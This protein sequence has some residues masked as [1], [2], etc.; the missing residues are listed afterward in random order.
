MYVNNI[1]AI[2]PNCCCCRDISVQRGR[3]PNRLQ[4]HLQCLVN[5][6]VKNGHIMEA[7][8]ISSTKAIQRKAG[9]LALT[10]WKRWG[11]AHAPCN[12]S[13]AVGGLQQRRYVK[14]LRICSGDQGVRLALSG[15]TFWVAYAR[16][17]PSIE[18]FRKYRPDFTAHVQCPIVSEP[19]SPPSFE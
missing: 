6:M 4:C 2:H 9:T 7:A 12:W 17:T 11:I 19:L 8:W 18:H 10:P 14:K 3:Q 5:R 1:Q 16:T 15:W 13:C